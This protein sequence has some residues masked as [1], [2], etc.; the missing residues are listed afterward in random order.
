MTLPTKETVYIDVD[1]D[2]TSIIDKVVSSEAELVAVVM[3][4]RTGSLQ[5]ITNMRLL[6]KASSNAQ[7]KV[8]L[9]T[10]EQSVLPLA[11]MAGV[12]IADSLS[13]KPY[14]PD[15]PDID[16][17]MP[18]QAEQSSEPEILDPTKPIAELE[19]NSK[20][21]DVDDGDIRDLD[22]PVD[23]APASTPKSKKS[24]RV[25]NF[26]NFRK[27][28]FIGLAGLVALLLL[29]YWAFFIVPSAEITISTDTSSSEL[30]FN[31]VADSSIEEPNE[32]TL[33]ARANLGEFTQENSK[34]VEAS[35]EEN[36]GERATGTMT[37]TNCINDG[38]EKTVPSGTAFTSDNLTFVTTRT[39]VLEEAVFSGFLC[40][41]A[42]FGQSQEVPVRAEKPG[43][44]YNIESTRYQ[45]SIS[46]IVASGSDMTGGTDRLVSVVSRSDVE[47]ARRDLLE[48]LSDSEIRERLSGELDQAGFLPVVGTYTRG[49]TSFDESAKVGDEVNEVTVSAKARHTMMGVNRSDINK[50]IEL[51]SSEQLDSASQVMVDSGLDQAQ[52]RVLDRQSE[53]RVQISISTI[54]VVGPDL[55]VNQIK[56]DLAKMRRGE[57]VRDLEGR[58]GVREAE[59][60]FSPFWVSKIPSR[61]DKVNIEILSV[62]D[63]A[64]E[65]N[66]G[67][68]VEE[69]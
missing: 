31:L 29:F 59:V 30:Q 40:R 61:A 2:V 35:G 53:N 18:S 9:V 28:L 45:S 50:F 42:E 8:V 5:S 65:T 13:S 17:A 46:G 20:L 54:I 26:N 7:K 44:E 47:S 12:H 57:V 60:A 1:D 14:I 64:E 21:E 24:V 67:D 27:K 51:E 36:R 52:I 3:P 32:E 63:A 68:V 37:L 69:E 55:D 48:N 10:K 43:T 11:G 39:V 66:T 16:N 33:L 41:S 25:P 56:A 6:K 62:D 15:K 38:V 22:A 4:K 23:L 58:T 49:D 19:S 34:T